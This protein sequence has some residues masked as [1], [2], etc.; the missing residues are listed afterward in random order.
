[1][2][3]VKLFNNKNTLTPNIKLENIKELFSSIDNINYLSNI[4]Y[5]ENYLSNNKELYNDIKNKVNKYINSWINLGKFD[6][7]EDCYLPNCNIDLQLKYYNKLFIDTFKDEIINYN[8]YNS[9]IENNPYN[10][11]FLIKDKKKKLSDFQ[12]DDYQYL[13]T[14]NYNDKFTLN[15]NFKRS[16]N[17]IPYYEKWIYNKHYDRE[18]IGSLSSYALENKNSKIYNNNELY[19]NLDYLK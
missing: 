5:R 18:D 1:M 9:E 14:N 2:D 6:N 12:A 7:I 8:L 17:N 13:N 3:I 4:L 15:T 19:N 16:Y 11:T 10:H